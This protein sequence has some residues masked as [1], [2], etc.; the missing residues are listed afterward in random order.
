MIGLNL[1]IGV[2]GVIT[3]ILIVTGIITIVTK[4]VY[5][6]RIERINNVYLRKL[7]NTDASIKDAMDF[8]ELKNGINQSE[9]V[10]RKINA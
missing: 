2:L 6:K 3:I 8:L 4:N 9:E 5:S 7:L 10:V 1:T